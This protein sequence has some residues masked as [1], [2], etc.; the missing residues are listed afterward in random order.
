MSDNPMRAATRHAHLLLA[1]SCPKCGAKTRSGKPCQGP[2]MR[3]RQRCR[4]H[5]A[6]AGA[7]CGQ[8]NGKW[9]HGLRSAEV[10]EARRAMRILMRQLR[11]EIEALGAAG[12][13]R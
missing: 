9:R 10:V 1:W 5:G 13:V 4:M 2:A 3:G 7:P 6:Q 11:E 8:A 12:S